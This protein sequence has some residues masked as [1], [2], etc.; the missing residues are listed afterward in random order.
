MCRHELLDEEHAVKINC[1]QPEAGVRKL[2]ST[3]RVQQASD[4]LIM[5]TVQDQE[6][7]H[8]RRLD[9]DSRGI[10]KHQKQVVQ[11][12]EEHYQSANSSV[13]YDHGHSPGPGEEHHIGLDHDLVGTKAVTV[14]MA[15]GDPRGAAEVQARKILPCHHRPAC[16]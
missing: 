16:H 7:E 5:A 15:L 1:G 10:K 2:E 14:A 3:I 4:V 8:H 6:N 9:H 13:H 12:P 11:K